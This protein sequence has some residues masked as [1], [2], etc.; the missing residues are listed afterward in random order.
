MSSI[1]KSSEDDHRIAVTTS[2]PTEGLIPPSPKVPPNVLRDGFPL[3]S[4]TVNIEGR[5][6]DYLP[7]ASYCKR[8]KCGGTIT[9]I[10]SPCMGIM[11]LTGKTTLPKFNYQGD[12]NSLLFILMFDPN[13]ILGEGTHINQTRYWQRVT[14]C[15]IPADESHIT[16]IAVTEGITET[17]SQALSFSVGAKV[18]FSAKVINA[19]LSAALTKSFSYSISI[20]SETTVSNEFPFGKKPA[21]QVVAVYQ[22]IDEYV[23]YPGQNFA[24]YIFEWNK[25]WN[26]VLG[27]E[28]TPEMPMTYPTSS[29]LQISGMDDQSYIADQPML[30]QEEIRMLVKNSIIHSA[31]QGLN[32]ASSNAR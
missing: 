14:Q 6:L 25:D 4:E 20:K 1:N 19:E 23:I 8:A 15:W 12:L 2:N 5:S 21:P 10:G 3:R 11:T 24:N 29:Y 32:P 31:E 30:S 17:E 9:S 7:M 28:F 22:L 13:S 27:E 16:K 26:Y 18:G